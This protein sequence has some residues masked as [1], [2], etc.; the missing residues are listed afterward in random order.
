MLFNN[1]SESGS[2]E[3]FNFDY[4]QFKQFLAKD[5]DFNQPKVLDELVLLGDSAFFDFSKEALHKEAI[6]IINYLKINYLSARMKEI[7]AAQKIH[8]C[9]F[10]ASAWP[11]NNKKFPFVDFQV[12]SFKSC[13]LNLSHLVSFPDIG[14]FN[15]RNFS[16]PGDL[17]GIQTFSKITG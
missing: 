12:Y 6:K 2:L 10:S 7:Q 3:N 14:K 5:T 8:K 17:F 11:E 1:N 4:N 9:T 15:K 13:K 16:V